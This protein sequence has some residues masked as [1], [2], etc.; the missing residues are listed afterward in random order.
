VTEQSSNVFITPN[1]A[2][3]TVVSHVGLCCSFGTAAQLCRVV[4][5][6]LFA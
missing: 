4:I 2:G 5:L 6:G 1:N 3:Q